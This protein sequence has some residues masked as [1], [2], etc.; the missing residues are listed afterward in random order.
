MELVNF[1]ARRARFTLTM[2][3]AYMFRIIEESAP[4]LLVDDTI[5]GSRQ[6]NDR[7]SSGPQQRTG[8]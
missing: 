2:S 3:A 7:R 4:T 5:F 1:W 8:R 6:K